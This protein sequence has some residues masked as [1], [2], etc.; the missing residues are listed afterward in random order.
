MAKRGRKPKTTQPIS[1]IH[2]EFEMLQAR[3]ERATQKLYT[4]LAVLKDAINRA[5][6]HLGTIES[7]D[8][9][10]EAAFKAGRAFNPIDKVNEKLEEMLDELYEDNDFDHWEDIVKH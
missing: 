7:S 3:T 6:N 4:D 5:F 8:N 9:L 2:Q 10:A 1:E